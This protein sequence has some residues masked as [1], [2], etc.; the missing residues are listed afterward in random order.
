ME[1]SDSS[2]DEPYGNEDFWAEQG[3][4]YEQNDLLHEIARLQAELAR[5]QAFDARS[6]RTLKGK[7]FC[8]ITG[9]LSAGLAAEEFV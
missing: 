5:R 3:S 4:F 6:L 2:D 8:V 1:R 7:T 9:F